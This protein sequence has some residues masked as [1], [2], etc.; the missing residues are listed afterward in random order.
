MGEI[1]ELRVAAIQKAEELQ[2]RKLD[3]QVAAK[4]CHE[5]TTTYNKA[6]MEQLNLTN[7]ILSVRRWIYSDETML[8]AVIRPSESML[9][10]IICHPVTKAGKLHQSHRPFAV[11]IERIAEHTGAFFQGAPDA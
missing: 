9:D 6:R 8:A 11:R 5:A 1:E 3:V 2:M 7:A 4:A 10:A